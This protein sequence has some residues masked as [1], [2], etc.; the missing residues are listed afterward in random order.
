MSAANFLVVIVGPTAVGKTAISI[1]LAQRLGCEVLS[2]DSRQFFKEM[3]IGTAKPTAEEMRGVPH[4]F[5]NFLPVEAEMSA[6]DFELMV[7]EKLGDLFSER[8][9]ALMVGGSGLYV[10]AVCEGMSDM[11]LAPREIRDQLMRELEQD[12]L[13]KLLGELKQKDPEYFGS[14]D[15]D[16]YQRVV[17]AL[18]MIRF[19]GEPFSNFR[20][21]EKSARNFEIITI[22]LEMDRET[23]YERINRR[24]DAM[25]EQGL[26]NE[27]KQLYPRR[28]LNALQTVGYKEIFDYLDGLHDWDEAVRLIKRNTR[29]Y[30]KRQ[31]TWFKKDPDIKWFHPDNFEEVMKYLKSRI[32]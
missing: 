4:H 13:E 28:H 24:V 5:I 9:V 27:A 29:R 22:G 14:V 31:M 2:A 15:H 21:G 3:S 12:G 8:N 1:E 7:L 19:T 30:A 20:R 23:L 32:N 6:G 16:N 18:E 25:L 17:R 11:P 26:L 10:K